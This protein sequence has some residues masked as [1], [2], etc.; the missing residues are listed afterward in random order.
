MEYYNLADRAF[1]GVVCCNSCDNVY[2]WEIS[3]D[4]LE[5]YRDLFN[6]V[7]C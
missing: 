2:S 3:S 5:K 7:G 4:I 6:D 1:Q